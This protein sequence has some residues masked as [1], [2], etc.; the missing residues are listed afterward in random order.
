MNALSRFL[1]ALDTWT[2]IQT[3]VPVVLRHVRLSAIEGFL[4]DRPR[5]FAFSHQTRS[6]IRIRSLPFT[7]MSRVDLSTDPA[8]STRTRV[9]TQVPGRRVAGSSATSV[10]VRGEDIPNFDI[11]LDCAN[12]GDCSADRTDD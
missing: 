10:E 1:T 2:Q 6:S 4:D 3:A 9:P 11:F 7:P 12:Q 5:P 8:E